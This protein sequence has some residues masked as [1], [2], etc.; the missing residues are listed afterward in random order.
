MI[1]DNSLPCQ[2]TEQPHVIIPMPDGCR[3][4]ARIWM[5]VDAS[6]DPVPAILE[7]LPYRKR[8][9]TVHRDE[10]GHPWMAAHR[11]ACI[12]VDMRGSGESEGLLDDEYTEQELQDACDV[13]AW[14]RAQPWCDGSV[15]MMGISWGGFNS[16][17]VAA[18]RPP[19]L[20]AIIT[21]CS[22][23]DRFADD[24]HYK[25]GCLLNENVG[26]AGNMLSYASPPPDP[27][28][29]GE[30][31]RKLWL[32]R[33]EQQP[34]LASTWLRH[35]TRDHY[36]QH[37]SVCENYSAI[38]A[39]VLTVGGWHDGYRNTISH[40]VENL[41]SPV[42]GIV[43]P[44]IHKYPHYA[45]P[46]PA[47]GFLQESLRWWNHWLKEKDNDIENEPDY[48]VWLMDS[49]APERWL[50]ERPGR[51]IAENSLPS[52]NISSKK[53]H[54]SSR[55]NSENG[56]LSEQQAAV[57][58]V[59][60]ATPQDLGCNTGEYFPFTFGPELPD[61][62]NTDDDKSIC[63][64]S[65]I[66][67]S[68]ID[69]V[70][71]PELSIK[72][73]SDQTTGLLVA[74]LCDLRPDG[75]SALITMGLLNLTHRQSS[76]N[77]QL[78]TPGEQF[79]ATLVLDQIAY[80]LPAGHQLRIALSTSY[81]PFIWPSPKATVISL[82]SAS[83]NLPVRK[84]HTTQ[85]VEFE[86]PV[87]APGWQAEQLRPTSS[88]RMVTT[89]ESGVVTTTIENDFGENRDLAH[90]LVSG[91]LAKEQWSIHPNDPL[92][93]EAI[94]YW[95]QTG[96]R[97]AWHWKTEAKVRMHSDEQSF[98]LQ[99]TLNVF[100]NDELIFDRQYDDIIAR[101]FV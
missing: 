68:A 30:G 65:A 84:N 43:G 77:P 33:L 17:Q 87:S 88:E 4:S 24:I 79:T 69:I 50:P 44:W 93:A 22:T 53:L 99:A 42:K 101:K 90:G 100:E 23:V 9:G 11:Y 75:S 3:L 35:Q 13:I 55:A 10:L 38:N 83:V 73:S 40:L 12:R 56:L 16:L 27:L 37:G 95:Q 89:D 25:G 62:Q 57:L 6:D 28:L 76:E 36:W 19:G 41:S 46:Q 80:R 45:E 18:L 47:I 85:A 32:E 92:S 20:N 31:W 2:I 94:I 64:D 58:Q 97:E 54:L 67:D 51:W 70:G 8:D 81:W 66:L 1:D 29:V 61:R 60:I 91:S 39:A 34:F 71:A 49:V 96:G 63:F 14:A 5:P 26:W 7:H 86:P 59:E 72:A 82:H 15:G 21:V 74:R 52:A 78:L 48:R 98:Y